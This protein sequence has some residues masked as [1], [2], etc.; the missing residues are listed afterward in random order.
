M[1]R[2]FKQLTLSLVFIALLTA[3]G[4]K[5]KQ[6]NYIPKDVTGVV[7]IDAKSLALKSLELKDLLS[8]DI[9]KK[10][11]PTLKDSIIDKVKNSGLDLLST[12]YIFGDVQKG[13][14]KNY[15]AI[16]F[17]LDDESK[18]EQMLKDLGKTTEVKTDNDVKYTYLQDPG[19]SAIIGWKDKVGI[20]VAVDSE[21]D[22]EKLK[23]KLT[24]LFSQPEENS[25]AAANDKFQ[26][27]LKE[28]ADLSVFI[29]YEKL[30]DL[31][32]QNAQ[33]PMMSTT[34]FKDTYLAATVN[35]ENGQ[36]VSNMKV[37]NNEENT[38][39]AKELYK[40]SVSKD[41]VTAQPGGNDVVAFMSFGVNMDAIIKHLQEAQLL[42]PLNQNLKT[43]GD[44]FDA[45][46]L[47]AALSGDFIGTVNA[48]NVKEV[49][50]M[51]Y[52]TGEMK[53]AK[54]FSV[55]Y[56]I[57]IGLK[58]AAKFQKLLDAVAA[59]GM[60]AKTG[61]YYSV[62]N[63]SFIFPKSNSIVV[64]SE[65]I[66]KDLAENKSNPLNN[67]YADLM[68][69]NTM[70]MGFD[71]SKVKPEVL[72][73]MGS[74]VNKTVSALPFESILI[75]AEEVKSEVVTGK[76]VVN[77]KNKEQN[78]LISLQQALKDAD[79]FMPQPSPYADNNISDTLATSNAPMVVDSVAVEDVR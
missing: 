33:S 11:V 30:G 1:K 4:K 24:G 37:Y 34:N 38:K 75:S 42:D 50:R 51:D 71:I 39:R 61:A 69:A 14:Q 74:D 21:S 16:V 45:N 59:K 58:D 8:M 64:S 5:P 28:G 3:C 40:A 68:N 20:V 27:L 46:Y 17:A 9:F 31:I 62:A 12:T 48:V 19:Q 56:A 54:D 52:L 43:F 13:D 57:T 60:I 73:L 65:G 10:N 63:T 15:V 23:S 78:S 55:E 7:T 35:F 47:A 49:S 22:K 25:L 44:E 2:T 26:T 53:P 6:L 76:T 36:I 79:K 32:K 72:D 18:F 29:N 41:L 70:A 67:T 66:V 77:F